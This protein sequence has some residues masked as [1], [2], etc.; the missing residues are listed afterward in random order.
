[1]PLGP[2]SGGS[3]NLKAWIRHSELNSVRTRLL[4]S[5][6]KSGMVTRPLNIE[7]AP[8]LVNFRIFVDGPLAS[9][10]RHGH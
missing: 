10:N 9:L 6:I 4:D 2:E 5:I 1:M 8:E 7:H 3:A